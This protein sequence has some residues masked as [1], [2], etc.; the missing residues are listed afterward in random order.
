VAVE[1]AL[2]G[3]LVLVGEPVAIAIP[4]VFVFRLVTFW[5]PVPPG[6]L[7]YRRL[8]AAGRI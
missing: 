2:I 4:A 1:A 5:L 3:G 7:A 6:W 8:G